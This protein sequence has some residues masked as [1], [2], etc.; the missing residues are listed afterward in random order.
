LWALL[1]IQF[2]IF[3]KEYNSKLFYSGT[4][5]KEGVFSDDILVK[6]IKGLYYGTQDNQER[7]R[8]DDIP[9]DL[10]GRIYE[11]Y[12]GVVLRGTEKRVKLDLLSGKRKS[13][14]IYYTPSYIVDYIVKNTIREYTKDKSIDEIFEVKV[15]DPACGSGSFLIGAFQELIDIIEMRLKKGEKSKKWDSFKEYKERLTLGQKATILLNCIYG[16]DL[17]E[18]AVELAQLN[19]LLKIL[20]EETR[21]K[22]LFVNIL[23]DLCSLIEELE[24]QKGRKPTLMKDIVFSSVLKEYLNTSSRRVQGDLKLFSRALD[25]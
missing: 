21:E 4:L 20:E 22:V 23:A 14:G 11:Q 25:Y 24:H 5:E 10:L 9:I 3:D 1:V 6:V 7:Y 8:F 15:L 2:K 18:K 17:D 19:L 16:V 13:M 12:L